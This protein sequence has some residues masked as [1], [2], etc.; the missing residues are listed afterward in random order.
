MENTT[1]TE[2]QK[3]R[4]QKLIKNSEESDKIKKHRKKLE[5]KY[6]SKKLE[7]I[8]ES[9]EYQQFEESKLKKEIESIDPKKLYTKYNQ[10]KSSEPKLTPKYFFLR[11]ELVLYTKYI[12]G[13]NKSLDI[14]YIKKEIMEALE[15][16][17]EDLAS[18][19]SSKKR[20]QKILNANNAKEIVQ[21]LEE[22]GPIIGGTSKALQKSKDLGIYETLEKIIE[23]ENKLNNKSSAQNIKKTRSKYHNPLKFIRKI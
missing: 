19:T 1:L 7:K 11:E 5:N 2:E 17:K 10:Q 23:I 3:K 6:T 12:D 8:P 4:L 20:A 16:I 15:T 13:E 22:K 14:K 21:A 18:M 9:E